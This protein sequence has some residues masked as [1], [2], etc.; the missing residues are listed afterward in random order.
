MWQI[1]LK[2]CQC[3]RIPLSLAHTHSTHTRADLLCR[4]LTFTVLHSR[5]HMPIP[6][7][8]TMAHV[9]MCLCHRQ[10]ETQSA[11]YE[12]RFFTFWGYGQHIPRRDRVIRCD[13]GTIPQRYIAYVLVEPH[14]GDIDIQTTI[15]Q[16]FVSEP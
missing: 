12:R 8:Y 15:T 13:C 14:E 7:R 1:V 3:T 2:Y 10:D 4:I 11:V 16:Y 9:Y 5:R 6:C